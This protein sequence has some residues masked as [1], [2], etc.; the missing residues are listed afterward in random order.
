MEWKAEQ[1]SEIPAR[2]GAIQADERESDD[3]KNHYS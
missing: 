3:R 1:C 2:K